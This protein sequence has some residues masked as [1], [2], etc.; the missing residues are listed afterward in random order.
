ML[1][2]EERVL[3]CQTADPE[4]V[5]LLESVKAN[6][7]KTWRRA[8]PVSGKAV[9][10]ASSPDSNVTEKVTDDVERGSCFNC[11]KVGHLSRDCPT[12]RKPMTCFRCVAAGHMVTNCPTRQQVNTVA[13][14]KNVE[15][16]HPYQKVGVV[17]DCEF[18]ALL[19]TGSHFTLFKS[20]LAIK[21]GVSVRPFVKPLY[22]VGSTVVPAL[23]T[24][25]EAVIE[26]V[27]D[28]VNAGPVVT[29][30]VPDDV[31]GPDA[32]IGRNWLD[33]LAVSYYKSGS[34]LV[35]AEANV[36]NKLVDA[37]V[38]TLGNEFDSLHV[39]STE[40]ELEHAPLDLSEFKFV[41]EDASASERSSLSDLVNKYRDCFATSLEE[42]GCTPLT[43]MDILEVTGSKPVMCKPYKTTAAD[44]AEIE[45]IVSDWK[46]CGLVVETRSPYASLVLLVKQSA[47]KHRLC[48]DYRRLN[49]QTLRQ[50]FP[51]PDMNEQ[52]HLLG[53]SKLF[54]QLNLASGYLQIPLTD[55]AAAKT[56]FITEDTTGQ[57][58]RMPFG[59]SG[60]V[61]EF[62]RLMRHVLGPL[63]GKIVRNYLD[64]MVVDAVDW[65]DML[66]KLRLVFDRLRSVC[67]TLKPSKCAFGAKQ[68]EF[69]GF[70]VGGGLIQPGE[71]KTRAISDFPTPVDVTSLKRFLGLTRYAI[72]AEPLTRLTKKN[73]DFLWSNKQDSAFRVLEDRLTEPPVLTMFNP[74]AEVTELNTDASSLGLGAMLL[75]SKKT[76]GSLKLVYCISKKTSDSESKYHSSKLE[77]MCVVW[78][79][80]KLRQ[81]LLGLQFVVYTDC[82]AL[83]YRP[84]NRMC[85]VDALSRA[86]VSS[87][88]DK[89][90]PFDMEL[91][92]RRDVCVLLTIEDK[93]RMCQV[94]DQEVSSIIQRLNADPVDYNLV[95]KVLLWRTDCCT[96]ELTAGYCS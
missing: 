5:T 57:F 73:A 42:F 39:V 74:N 54:A 30:I 43:S 70:I 79:M 91:E 21:C 67:L 63:H 61:V 68:I 4:I 13:E 9:A 78:A 76:G 23:E 69:L 41:S 82:Q 93:V 16:C 65:D 34:Q 15:A 84:G 47:G 95:D 80:S 71:L 87:T 86:P 6:P 46:R 26:I 51:L 22:G 27:I 85:H 29:L 38:V 81:F 33:S 72:I 92:D 75:Q 52:L 24:V 64:D 56:A 89:E 88:G 66:S 17:N 25:G 12:K 11:H 20:T 60:A 45:G 36:V 37:T 10:T 35:L 49:K 14:Q 7:E 53:N 90:L 32:I 40:G 94:A 3:M 31:Q 55:E 83:V 77:L 18:V 48:V 58:T 96:G 28:G 62:T 59:L 8:A 1:T 44:R 2:E 50:H 19:D